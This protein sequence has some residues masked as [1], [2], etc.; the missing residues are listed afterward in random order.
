[1]HG[2]PKAE[3]MRARRWA[4]ALALG[5]TLLVLAAA[6]TDLSVRATPEVPAN[7]LLDEPRE[8]QVQGDF[9]HPATGFPMPERVGPFERVG[10]TQYDQAGW[11]LSAGY[12]AMLGETTPLPV[13]ATVYVYPRQTGDELDAYFET[14]LAD[15]GG[16]HGGARPEF[17]K[18]IELGVGRLVGR[19]AIFGYAE[20][21]GGLTKEVPLRSYLVLYP[22]KTWWVKWRVTTPAPIDNE[23][24]RRIAD[25]TESLL[26]PDSEPEEGGGHTDCQRQGSVRRLRAVVDRSSRTDRP[27]GLSA[28]WHQ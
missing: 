15:I 20:P 14:L 27:C 3:A 7:T 11:N 18:N 25:L 12:N 21:W 23:R 24:M 13:V 17:R 22:W 16:S 5:G 8:F 26:P 19:Y 1:M 10:V 4:A 2:E 28:R 9:V 6:M